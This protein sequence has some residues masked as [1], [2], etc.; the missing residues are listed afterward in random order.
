MELMQQAGM[1]P[2]Q[3]LVAATRNAAFACGK[4][5]EP[6][7]IEAGKYTDLLVV[8]GKALEDLHDL[9]RIRYVIKNGAIIRGAENSANLDK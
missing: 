7:T 1:T 2:M 5:Q 6:G 9:Q 3:I 8:N 4:S